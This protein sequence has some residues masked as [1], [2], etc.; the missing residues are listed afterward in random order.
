M[1]PEEFV[2]MFMGCC[3][4]GRGQ[5]T[6]D[7]N[8]KVY[9][10]TLK[11]FSVSLVKEVFL[12]SVDYDP[13]NR[14]DGMPAPGEY[15]KRCQTL[16]RM[17]INEKQKYEEQR[18]SDPMQGHRKEDIQAYADFL[19]LCAKIHDE[20]GND[21]NLSKAGFSNIAKCIGEYALE[22]INNMKRANTY[23]EKVEQRSKVT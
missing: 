20:K 1:K 4:L 19:K 17:K 18:N 6:C 7:Q 14:H 22:T 2:E 13:L 15:L 12:Q 5:D 9:Y 3:R 16:Y 11:G 23:A 21:V 10:Q 8:E